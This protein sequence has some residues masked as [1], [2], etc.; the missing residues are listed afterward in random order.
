MFFF[1]NWIS[2]KNNQ[3]NS[4]NFQRNLLVPEPILYQYITSGISIN[5][6]Y[7]QLLDDLF[8]GDSLFMAGK[9]DN[10]NIF[11]LKGLS[12]TYNLRLNWLQILF[13]NRLGFS[14][15]WNENLDD[16]IN[17]YSKSY[18]L[19]IHSKSIEDTLAAFEAVSFG[20][21]F[22]DKL[23]DTI[24]KENYK[25]SLKRVMCNNFSDEQRNAKYCMLL[26]EYEMWN[27]DLYGSWTHL[28]KAEKSVK[29]DVPSSDIW[30]F[31]IRC[32][33]AFYY[34]YKADYKLSYEYLEALKI[35][36][37]NNPKFKFLYFN[38]CYNLGVVLNYLYSYGLSQKILE[39]IHPLVNSKH[40]IHYYEYYLWLGNTYQRIGKIE[41]SQNCFIKALEIL[42][43]KN[44]NDLNTFKAYV[45]LAIFYE[46]GVPNPDLELKYLKKAEKIISRYPGEKYYS[47]LIAYYLGRQ[48]FHQED[49]EKALDYLDP[50]LEDIDS[51]LNSDKLF[52]SKL[53][54]FTGTFFQLMLWYRSEI[55]YKSAKKNNY[56]LKLMLKS[57]KNAKDLVKFGSKYIENIDYEKSK[58]EEMT[59][60]KS[61]YDQLLYIG[62]DLINH[63]DNDS[64]KNELFEYAEKSKAAI[65]KAYVTEEMSKYK[66]GIPDTLI[67][68]SIEIK[69]ELDTLQYTLIQQQSQFRGK[70]D[71]II[72]NN[73]LIKQNEYKTLEKTLEKKY[74]HYTGLKA[75]E[76]KTSIAQIQADLL[77]TQTVLEY[78]IAFDRFFIFYIDKN[79]Y[80]IFSSTISKYFPDSII[81]YQNLINNIQYGNYTKKQFYKFLEQSYGFYQ[82]LI[83]P[84]EALIKDKRLI[85]VPDQE[86]NLI[87]FETLITKNIDT[88]K[89]VGDFTKLPYLILNNPI[90]Y[91]YS[92]SELSRKQE[93]RKNRIRFA[94]FAPDYHTPNNIN[95]NLDSLY[96]SHGELPGAKNEILS[97]RKYYK[98][99]VFLGDDA[100]KEN[101]FSAA[102]NSD[103]IHLAM[104][105]ILDMDEPM[106]SEMIFSP[107][108]SRS[109]KQLHAF[110][111]Y[112][113]NIHADLVVLSACN[114]GN[115]LLSKGEGVF[116]IAR[117][118]LLAGVKN[119]LITQWPI[120]D[121]SSEY[122][123]DRFY[124]YLSRGN[125]VDIALQ[126]A[127]IDCI[128]QGDPVKAAPYYWA[129]YVCLGNPTVLYTKKTYWPIIVMVGIAILLLFYYRRLRI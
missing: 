24:K 13:C 91:I 57:Y 79:T 49:Y 94:G 88:T 85:I 97:A 93:K 72:I 53:G 55:F 31:L 122:L 83:K 45:F 107:D 129:G 121:K 17:Y 21:M 4:D 106:N 3:N 37:T 29:R 118:F 47:T 95:T 39:E 35:Q 40:Y 30:L 20:I 102:T 71:N 56:D 58:L 99:K 101:Y 110:E 54:S 86:L 78:Q 82:L 116:S 96:S 34:R 5:R 22:M 98:G 69:K 104:H 2:A 32:N 127:K 90:S 36:I 76:H 9:P 103:I 67:K 10:A 108:L 14:N 68:R 60:L 120:A 43:S 119:I 77:P 25:Y 74:P 123:M 44:V 11:Y 6:K 26:A 65:L 66:A 7:K 70:T 48:Y 115:G 12:I 61:E 105:S 18:D 81:A 8:L 52:Y 113:H 46:T 15:Y 111:V 109:D 59:F 117:A 33:K 100:S 19:I 124:Y 73:I 112:S 38:I 128:F 62:C 80:K 64:I 1:S 114:T 28:E 92:V 41:L 125:P 89:S 84:V 63:F 126:K 50:Q 23:S 42:K 51:V 87:P 75:I 27:N 16:A